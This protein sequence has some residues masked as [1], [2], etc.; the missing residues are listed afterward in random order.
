M[1]Q[2]GAPSV[3]AVCAE[4][5]TQEG[6]GELAA[7][8]LERGEFGRRKYGTPLQVANGRDPLADAYEE[9]LD[10]LAYL[11]QD[12]LRRDEVPAGSLY[13]AGCGIGSL[14]DDA[15]RLAAGIRERRLD[16]LLEATEPASG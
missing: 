2:P 14:L 16:G 12:E 13:G 1:H 11:A 9:V 4:W 5:L 6:R 3:H 7:D 10:A 8:L 15:A